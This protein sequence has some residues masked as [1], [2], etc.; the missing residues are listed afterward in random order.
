MRKI[1]GAN[2][3]KRV[4]SAALA[5]VLIISMLVNSD[6]GMVAKADVTTKDE[7]VTYDGTTKTRVR[8]VL[9][10]LPIPAAS[11]SGAAYDT[12][13][14]NWYNGERGT[15]DRPFLVLEIVPYYE[16]GNFGYLI[17][18]CEPVALERMTGNAWFDSLKGYSTLFKVTE[19]TGNI[20]FFTDEEEGKQSYYLHASGDY[21]IDDWNW[22]NTNVKKEAKVLFGYYE[23]VE[24]G[25][26]YFRIDEVDGKK[27]IVKADN[28]SVDKK[29]TLNWHTVNDY[30]KTK[31]EANGYKEG[32]SYKKYKT[33]E[34]IQ[35]TDGSD[36]NDFLTNIVKIDQVGSRY[37]TERTSSSE[38]PYVDV[39][40]KLY[41]YSNNDS[42]A[43]TAIGL[44][45]EQAKTY[46]IWVKTIT[47]VELNEN[48]QWADIADLVFVQR[49]NHDTSFTKLFG[50]KDK[51][52]AYYNRLKKQY[53]SNCEQQSKSVFSGTYES[54]DYPGYNGKAKD[55]SWTVAAKLF[56]RTASAKNYC[57]LV[58]DKT[59]RDGIDSP[60][61][62]TGIQFSVYDL[63]DNKITS[64]NSWTGEDKAYYCNMGKLWTMCVSSKPNLVWRFYKDKLEGEKTTDPNYNIGVFKKSTNRSE[65]ER[66]YWSSLSFYF[67]SSVYPGV[68]LSS[69]DGSTTYWEDYSGYFNTTKDVTYVHGHVYTYNGNQSLFQTFNSGTT[70]ARSDRFKSFDEYL[71]T[72]ART[73]EIWEL[74]ENKELWSKANGNATPDYSKVTT[75][76]IAPWAALRYILDLDTDQ[77]M[78]LDELKVLDIEPSVALGKDSSKPVWTLTENDVAMMVP[79]IAADAKIDIVHEIMLSFVGR[80][81]DINGLY[82][83]VYLGDDA[84]GFWMGADT[85]TKTLTGR[86]WPDEAKA[87]NDRTNF[88]DDAMDG[89][90]YFHI[91]DIF[92]IGSSNRYAKHANFISGVNTIIKKDG[93]D[94]GITRQSGNDLTNVKKKTLIEYLNADYAVVAAKNL[95][96]TGEHPYVDQ[97]SDSIIWNFLSK[98]RAEKASDGT[99]GRGVLL[100]TEVSE[101]DKRVFQRRSYQMKILETPVAYNDSNKVGTYLP[102]ESGY[103]KL[104]FKV[105]VPEVGKYSYRIYVDQDRNGK[106]VYSADPSKTEVIQQGSIDSKI[107]SLSAYISSEWIGFIQWKIEIY[108]NDNP[109][110]R[111]TQEGC[112]AIRANAGVQK[113]KIIAL[114][115]APNNTGQGYIDIS[116]HNGNGTK[117]TSDWTKL[118]DQADDFEIEVYKISYKEF[119]KLFRENNGAK[120]GEGKSYGFHFNMGEKIDVASSTPLADTNPKRDVLEKIQSQEDHP[121][122]VSTLLGGHKLSD[123]NMMILGFGDMYRNTDM[124][125]QYGCAEYLFYFAEAGNSILFTHDLTIFFNDIDANETVDSWR[126]NHYGYTANTMLRSIMGQNRYGVVSK[127]I[128]YDTTERSNFNVDGTERLAKQLAKY[129]ANKGISFDQTSSPYR[130]GFTYWTLTSKMGSYSGTDQR[131]MYKYHALN[132]ENT[133]TR[134]AISTGGATTGKNRHTD[135]AVKLNDGQITSYPFHIDEVLKVADTH[136][137]YYSLNMEDPELTVWYTMEDGRAYNNYKLESGAT[138][139][140]SKNTR[141][142]DDIGLVYGVTPQNPS[143][144]FYIYSKGNIFYSGVGHKEVNGDPERKLFVNTLIAAYRPKYEKPE[145]LITNTEATLTAKKEYTIRVD[146][147]FD[148]NE[149]NELVSGLVVGEDEIAIT[150]IPR[151]YSGCSQVKCAIYYEDGLKYFGTDS[152]TEPKTSKIYKVKN[153]GGVKTQGDA[154]TATVLGMDHYYML[155]TEQE[156]MIYY[157][158]EN[159]TKAAAWNHIQFDVQNDKVLGGEPSVTNLYIKPRP[160]FILD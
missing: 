33:L 66:K 82:D 115:I 65:D 10:D 103:G 48:P 109:N 84:G 95:Y 11:R 75:E 20:Y 91:G 71:K 138:F 157:P 145:I 150:F 87:G 7:T 78:L 53:Y 89:L 106:F 132:P 61:S 40:G 154:V 136:D 149:D 32:V 55:I 50:A 134:Y 156:Y 56:E 113:N 123:F 68:Q 151:D 26:G 125:N 74:P 31:W 105:Q 147:E 4:I 140:S 16:Q 130:Q 46:S 104:S 8:G 72:N 92:Y 57:G 90:V 60:D 114:Q 93:N 23:C 98:N 35:A 99:Y 34:E 29:G 3:K 58:F 76:N 148:Y 51:S 129:D 102:K 97:S 100:N 133:G 54:T 24:E 1:K 111:L 47:P 144:N 77:D 137:Q 80:N 81:E 62:K 119:E 70:G 44:T 17:E 94:V 64:L 21:K 155:D 19:A 86:T 143:D 116:S 43:L 28:A 118:Y 128:T 73:K 122:L 9:N 12:W 117:K 108:R 2:L 63:N 25:K 131:V 160:L 41:D 83:M 27:K 38:D 127:F 67:A 135:T 121:G 59:F 139:T 45:K 18:G 88:V 101:I 112:S 107:K 22:N 142:G 146:Q 79:S 13:L 110:V 158:K 96:V 49:Y 85:T 120:E 5:V 52:G 153:V 36:I 15:V 152:S 69:V 39:T 37:F 159:L 126:D 6:W 124:S 141:S 42:F 14:T 30:L